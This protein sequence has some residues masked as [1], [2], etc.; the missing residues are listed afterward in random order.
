MSSKRSGCQRA[1]QAPQP[2]PLRAGRPRLC[3]L[4]A[5][6]RTPPDRRDPADRCRPRSLALLDQLQSPF[7]DGEVAQAEEVH[8]EQAERIDAV[9][10]YWVTT[11][12]SSP[13]RCTGTNSVSGPG[14]MTTAAAW[15]ESWRRRPSRPRATSTTS[16]SA[17]D[18]SRTA[19][20]QLG[21]FV[22]IDPGLRESASRGQGIEASDCE[23]GFPPQDWRWHGLGEAITDRIWMS[24]HPGGIAQR[25]LALDRREGDDLRDMIGAVLLGGVT[26]DVGA[27]ALV[28]VHVDVGHLH[29]APD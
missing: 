28:E 17:P 15:I 14:E 9:I 8:L 7:D 26:D 1:D 18:R 5:I 21:G 16:F 29:A 11:S 24:Q 10:S 22:V 6:G 3:R 19:R 13:L 2:A 23:P 27:V 12:A 4:V 20:T 25:L